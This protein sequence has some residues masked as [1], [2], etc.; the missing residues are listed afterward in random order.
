MHQRQALYAHSLPQE[1]ATCESQAE[2]IP[3]RPEHTFIFNLPEKLVCMIGLLLGKPHPHF[4]GNDEH[5]AMVRVSK[6]R[7][8]TAVQKCR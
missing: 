4:F 6:K 1:A 8:D 2:W 5:F 7:L 3:E